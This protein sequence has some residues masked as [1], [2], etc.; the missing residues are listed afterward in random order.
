MGDDVAEAR[1]GRVRAGQ[2]QRSLLGHRRALGNPLFQ[3][4][5]EVLQIFFRLLDAGEVEGHPLEEQRPAVV[6]VAHHLGF[7]VNPYRPPIAC[8]EA[9]DRTE[10]IPG[11]TSVRELNVPAEAVVG[12]ELRV[13]EDRVIQ[14][15]LLG[16]TE[17]APRSAG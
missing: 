10:R 6:V 2:L 7:A 1:E 15:L 11:G 4:P 5:V 8:D 17:Q 16:E 12:V 13:P 9:I 3:R 14:P